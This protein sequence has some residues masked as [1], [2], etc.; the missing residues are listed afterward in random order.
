M[1]QFDGTS[2]LQITRELM[3]DVPF[4]FVL[5]AIDEERGIEALHDGA[6][7]YVLKDN[8]R[9]LPL[10]VEAWVGVLGRASPLGVEQDRARLAEIIDVI[11]D[12][13]AIVETDSQRR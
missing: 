1:P 4:I 5:G 9:R 12:L 10:V 2:A 8:L 7:D 13:V 6:A 3:P 11:G